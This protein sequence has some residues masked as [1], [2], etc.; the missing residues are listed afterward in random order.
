MQC[1]IKKN[2]VVTRRFWRPERQRSQYF[3]AIAMSWG[4]S[5]CYAEESIKQQTEGILSK[6]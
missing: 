1:E 3:C 2:K 6:F 4:S 5:G